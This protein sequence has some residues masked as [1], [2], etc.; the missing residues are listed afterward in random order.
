MNGGRSFYDEPAVL[1]DVDRRSSST[2]SERKQFSVAS[3][4][5]AGTPSAGRVN[6]RL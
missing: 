3:V 6:W 1:A 4:P 2:V 5:A